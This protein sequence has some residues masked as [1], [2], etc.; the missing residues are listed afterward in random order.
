MKLGYARVSKGEETLELQREA[1]RAAGAVRIWQDQDVSGSA[2]IKPAFREMLAYAQPGDEI[3]VWR[4]DRLARSLITLMAE[5]ETLGKRRIELHSLAEALA[6]NEKSG[7][8][9]FHAVAA[10]RAFERDV[11][12]ERADAER[13]NSGT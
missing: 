2:V 1:L 9:F 11:L 8:S 6:T 3:I 13:R 5:L 4:L 12:K 10:F 7:A